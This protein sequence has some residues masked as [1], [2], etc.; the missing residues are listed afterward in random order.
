M[1]WL[2]FIMGARLLPLIG[3]DVGRVLDYVADPGR[4]HEPGGEE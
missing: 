4:Y 3:I 1:N 2:A